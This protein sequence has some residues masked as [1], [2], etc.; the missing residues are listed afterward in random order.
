MEIITKQK[1]KLSLS[2]PL[3]KLQSTLLEQKKQNHVLEK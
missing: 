3:H 1:Q 2:T